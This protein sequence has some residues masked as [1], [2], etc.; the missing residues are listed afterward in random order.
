MVA[1]ENSNLRQY[2]DL[3]KVLVMALALMLELLVI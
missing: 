1:N 2:Q 3:G